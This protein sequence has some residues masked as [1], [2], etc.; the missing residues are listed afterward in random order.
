MFAD[1]LIDT[2][3]T[4]RSRRGWTTLASLAAQAVQ[5]A[6]FRMLLLRAGLFG[7]ECEFEV[8]PEPLRVE[9]V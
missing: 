7:P 6:L 3:W 8:R 1:S 5:R 4:D 2:P 9:A